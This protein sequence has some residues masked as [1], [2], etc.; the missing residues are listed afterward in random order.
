MSFCS[1]RTGFSE[2]E[3]RPATAAPEALGPGLALVVLVLEL[4]VVVAVVVA[5]KSSNQTDGARASVRP[6]VIACFEVSSAR[7][8]DLNTEH[9]AAMEAALTSRGSIVWPQSEHFLVNS[10]QHRPMNTRGRERG[11]TRSA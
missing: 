10:D 3:V 2:V 4:A 1:S 7:S 5:M 6:N 11:R 9:E 8:Y